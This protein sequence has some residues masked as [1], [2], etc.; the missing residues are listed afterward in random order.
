MLTVGI[1]NNSWNGIALAVACGVPLVC[2]QMFHILDYFIDNGNVTANE[3]IKM[4]FMAS[5]L[6]LMISKGYFI[7]LVILM[8]GVIIL[9]YK[10]GLQNAGFVRKRDK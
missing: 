1:L 10:K 7:T 3:I 8:C 4:V 9:I 5:A 2:I 6:Q